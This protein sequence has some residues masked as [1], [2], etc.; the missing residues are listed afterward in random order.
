[1]RQQDSFEFLLHLLKLIS[2][3]TAPA[4]EQKRH[5]IF[6]PVD[7]FRFHME[8]KLQCLSCKKVKYRTDEM[9]NIS[10]AVPINR[11]PKGA[12]TT[13]G[14]TPMLDSDKDA[15]KDEFEPVSFRY[16]SEHLVSAAASSR[17]GIAETACAFRDT[18]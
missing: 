4:K 3:S 11:K 12:K 17:T 8:Q 1:M 2:R 10:V 6:D 14:D 15:E 7:A 16:L 13:N 9:E 18:C 5:Q